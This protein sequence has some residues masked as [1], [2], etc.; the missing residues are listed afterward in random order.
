MT[1]FSRVAL[2]LLVA[3]CATPDA[4][5]P[6]PA[7]ATTHTGLVPLSDLTGTYLGY[8]GLLYPGSNTPP[9]AQDSALRAA[10]LAV[11]PRDLV[12]QPDPAG[13]YIFLSVGFSN[14]TQEWC[15]PHS[16]DPC[17]NQSFM[18]QAKRQTD[19]RRRAD[20]Q[21]V[22]NGADGKQTTDKWTQP[23][24]AN[25]DR[26]DA[27]I[28]SHNADPQQV[29]AVWFKIAHSRPTVSLPSPQ[30]DAFRLVQDA[31]DA[32]RAMRV[33]WPHLQL[34]FMASRT[35]AGYAVT[36]LN[37]EPYAYE[38]GLAVKWLITA[39]IQQAATGT[40]DPLA[41]DLSPAVAPRLAWGPYLWADGLTPR[42]DGLTWPRDAF[43]AD[44]THP[45]ND[46]ERV[47]GRLLLDFFR[48]SPYSCWFVT[49]GCGG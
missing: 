5:A 4:T 41:G 20:G 43:E 14:A 39:Q 38:S 13:V 42:S 40:V 7:L 1:R 34:V 25:Y 18:G 27:L 31:G 32:V 24:M 21:M 48:T 23:T 16:G 6:P 12:G 33:R 36:T 46:G 30:A 10:A 45:S 26:V 29:A 17:T 47:V 37:P 8:P 3:A 19:V 15:A 9:P 49:S 44:G 2:V 11:V 22:L 28:R 35:Y